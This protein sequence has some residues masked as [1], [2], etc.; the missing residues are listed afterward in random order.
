MK[1]RSMLCS[2]DLCKRLLYAVG[3]VLSDRKTKQQCT[4]SMDTMVL[5]QAPQASL[6]L[7]AIMGRPAVRLPTYFCAFLIAFETGT[8]THE[9]LGVDFVEGIVRFPMPLRNCEDLCGFCHIMLSNDSI[10]LNRSRM[11]ALEPP[12]DKTKC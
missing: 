12:S 8:C 9:L 7:G 10:C 5:A 6:R 11:I 1:D 2:Q 4:P 3:T